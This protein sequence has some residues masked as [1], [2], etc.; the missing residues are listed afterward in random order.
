MINITTKISYPKTADEKKAYQLY[1][2]NTKKK[3]KAIKTK[4]KKAEVHFYTEGPV[5]KTTF[6]GNKDL[7][8]Q[9]KKAV[10]GR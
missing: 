4:G 3:I 9:I 10:F 5:I 1:L 6:A 8:K 2:K 7:V